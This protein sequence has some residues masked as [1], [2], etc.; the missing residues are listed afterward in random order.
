MLTITLANHS[1]TV[2]PGESV[3]DALLRNNIE[4]AHTCGTA[5]CKR[6]IA[7]AISGDIPDT[8]QRTLSVDQRSDNLF[9]VCVCYPTMD[10]EIEL[11]QT[12]TYVKLSN[13]QRV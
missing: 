13:S 11:P 3:L 2:A 6:C 10:M 9:L 8:S 7:K 12:G 4:V 1:Y 5:I